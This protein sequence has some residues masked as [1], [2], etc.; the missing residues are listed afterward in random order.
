MIAQLRLALAAIVTLTGLSYGLLRSTTIMVRWNTLS[1]HGLA[2]FLLSLVLVVGLSR[3]LGQR[4]TLWRRRWLLASL[5]TAIWSATV[6]ACVYQNVRGSI[7]RLEYAAFVVPSSWIVLWLAWQWF[8]PWK[9]RTRVWGF[10]VT[11]M[12]VMCVVILFEIQG[13][14]GDGLVHVARRTWPP[15]GVLAEGKTERTAEVTA[16]A[17]ALA[18]SS[19]DDFPQFRGPNRNGDANTVQLDGDWQ[20]NPPQEL[21]RQPVGDGWGGFAVAG[22]YAITQ[23]QRGDKECIVA[24]HLQTGDRLWIHTDA[25][26]FESNYGGLGPRATPAT[27]KGRVFAVGAIGILNC[28]DLA[29]GHPVWN[30]DLLHGEPNLEHGV[31]FSPLIIDDLVIV[32]STGEGGPC[33]IAFDVHSGVK[34]WQAGD[35]R[36]SYASPISATIGGLAQVLVF[37]EEGVSGFALE[38]GEPL[39]DFPWS[40]DMKTNASQPIVGAGASN[41]VLV[42]TGYDRGAALFSLDRDSKGDWTTNTIWQSRDLDTK[43]SSPICVGDSVYGLD[44]GILACLDIATGRRRWKRGRYGHGQLLLVS[45][46]L[47]VQ[48]ES[49]E[50]VLVAPNPDQLLELA[51]LHLLSDKTWNHLALAGNLLLA[52]NNRE[53]VCL[54]VT[55]TDPN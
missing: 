26:R 4:P 3:G 10:A 52:R 16:A 8:G 29:T 21:W 45:D 20:T 30:A 25:A 24:Y 33:V 11:L 19:A 43:F 15:M 50:L 41:Q 37:H 46:L 5:V 28:L 32:S 13:A 38:D 18:T 36:A 54:Q 17:S 27:A 55:V 31:S 34:R 39:W 49:G 23:E 12:S 47:L 7:S 6:I 35:V 51:R 1:I 9:L 40:N 53:A 48:C 44:N 42:S 22:D 2:V 14:T